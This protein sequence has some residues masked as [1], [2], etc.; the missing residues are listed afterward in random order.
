[1]TS[2]EKRSPSQQELVKGALLS[3]VMNAV[4]NGAIQ[5]WLLRG[6]DVIPLSVDS[7]SAGTPT[8]LGSAVPLA[9]SLAMVL[10]AVAHWTLKGPKKP[11]FPT[12][13]W[14]VLKHGLFAFGALVAGAIVWQRVVGTV[15]VGLVTAVILLGLIAGIISTAVNYM[16]ISEIIMDHP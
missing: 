12:T 6:N 5:A 11:F 14:L 8:V 3:G 7:I 16:T 9:V 13:F 4:I 2:T 1:M 10:T 15:D